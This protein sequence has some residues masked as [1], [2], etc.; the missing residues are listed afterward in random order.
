MSGT[1]CA[2][3]KIELANGPTDT[4]ITP[5]PRCGSIVRVCDQTL[6]D[7]MAFHDGHRVKAKNP[8]LQSSKKLRIDAYSGVEHSRKFGKLVRVHRTID[9][10]NKWYSEQ[11][12]DLQTGELLH[13][14]SEP[15]PQHIGHG[16][17]KPKS[18]P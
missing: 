12:V 18:K 7:G 14:C 2:N 8:A 16:T 15:L 4:D 13:E 3:C 5:C 6:T 9:K 1:S 17:A 10:D 11:V